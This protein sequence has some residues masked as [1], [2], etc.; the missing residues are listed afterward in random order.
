V[1]IDDIEYVLKTD[2]YTNQLNVF[3]TLEGEKIEVQVTPIS[4][5][6]ANKLEEGI[7]V[8]EAEANRRYKFVIKDSGL[9]RIKIRKLDEAGTVLSEVD[10]Y[11]TFSYSEEYNAFP[12]REPLGKELL[13]VIA[14]DGKGMVI[15]DHASIFE[16]FDKTLKKEFD[17]RIVFLIICIVAVL[18]D[19]AVRKFKFKWPHE[20]VREYKRKKLERSSKN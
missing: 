16:N 15:E 9:Y 2:N 5:S 10:F 12:E 3:G 18:L 8:S 7:T 1:R 20:L 14:R 17:P 4:A 19:I 6:L 11:K 13:S